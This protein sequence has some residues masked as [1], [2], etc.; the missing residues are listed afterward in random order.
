MKTCHAGHH[1]LENLAA[2][3]ANKKENQIETE[4]QTK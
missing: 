1:R 3:A 2:F 4:N